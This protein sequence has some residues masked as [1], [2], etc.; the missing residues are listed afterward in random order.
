[1]AMPSDA[2]E[3][4]GEGAAAASDYLASVAAPSTDAPEPSS[5]AHDRAREEAITPAAAQPQAAASAKSSPLPRA[6]V[7]TLR[8]DERPGGAGPEPTQAARATA[9]AGG[10]RFALLAAG[11]TFAAAIGAIAGTAGMAGLE[12]LFVSAPKAQPAPS[13]AVR[14]D[15]HEE[16]RVLKE[17]VTQLKSNVKALSDNV[18]ALRATVNLSTSAANAQLTKIGD[19]LDRGE[20]ERAEHDRV[21]RDRTAERERSERARSEQQ[22]R[23]AALTPAPE[24]TGS[25]PAAQSAA[26]DPKGAT[27]NPVV[28]GWSLRKVYGADSALVEGRYGVVEIEPGDVVPGLGRIQEIRRQDGRWVVVTSRGLVVSSR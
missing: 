11:L 9:R 12:H 27:K 4:H 22:Q 20:R 18:A 5:I 23:A 19:A 6:A 1:M 8:P 15:G 3:D 7:L 26:I 17:T 10:R 13:V 25:V 24:P 28:E 21:E 16:V 14:P 2:G